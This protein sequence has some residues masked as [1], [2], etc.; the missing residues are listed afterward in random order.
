MS[1]WVCETLTCLTMKKRNK[2]YN[3]QYM[4]IILSCQTGKLDEE[5]WF[6]IVR[7]IH[8]IWV[9]KKKLKLKERNM[10]FQS[11]SHT[12]SILE[13]RWG[14]WQFI[15]ALVNL[16]C[17]ADCLPL[18]ILYSYIILH[19]LRLM[20]HIFLWCWEY[21]VFLRTKRFL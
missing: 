11:A 6:I 17:D 18:K 8:S 20:L 3:Q 4:I 16:C 14:I 2:E 1:S 21:I 10:W 5:F 12:P 13:Q 7:Q 19:C 9:E 15:Y